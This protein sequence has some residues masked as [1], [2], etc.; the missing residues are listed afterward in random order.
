MNNNSSARLP[1]AHVG[2]SSKK[3]NTVGNSLKELE[4]K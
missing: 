3:L 4:N 1:E 2:L